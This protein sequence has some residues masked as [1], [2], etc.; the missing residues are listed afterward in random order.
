MGINKFKIKLDNKIYISIL[1]MSGNMD[2]NPQSNQSVDKK[3]SSV[4]AE[5]SIVKPTKENYYEVNKRNEQIIRDKYVL[6]DKTH[7]EV[8]SEIQTFNKNYKQLLELNQLHKQPYFLPSFSLKRLAQEQQEQEQQGQEPEPEPEPE[9]QQQDE[10]AS[11]SQ[12]V[13]NNIVAL[14]CCYCNKNTLMN[15]IQFNSTNMMDI[16]DFKQKSG[17]VPTGE[18]NVN[19]MSDKFCSC[20]NH[21]FIDCSTRKL[22]TVENELNLK[23]FG[24]AA[25][26]DADTDDDD[27]ARVEADDDD[28]GDDEEEGG[29]VKKALKKVGKAADK[30]VGKAADKKVKFKSIRDRNINMVFYCNTC[31]NFFRYECL[32]KINETPS[33]YSDFNLGESYH[34]TL[35]SI[36]KHM[37]FRKPLFDPQYGDNLEKVARKLEVGISLTTDGGFPI[38]IHGGIGST[39]SKMGKL[40]L[41]GAAAGYIGALPGISYGALGGVAGAAASMGSSLYSQRGGAKASLKNVAKGA[42]KV[43]QEVETVAQKSAELQALMSEIGAAAQGMVQARAQAQDTSNSP[44]YTQNTQTSS[45]ATDKPMIQK[46]FGKRYKDLQLTETYEDFI[47]E[48]KKWPL[49]EKEDALIQAFGEVK[50]ETKMTDDYKKYREEYKKLQELYIKDFND[51][52]QE[53]KDFPFRSKDFIFLTELK[54]SLDSEEDKAFVSEPKINNKKIKDLKSQKVDDRLGQLTIK[55]IDR[56]L[57][58]LDNLGKIDLNS[59]SLISRLLNNSG[60]NISSFDDDVK[61][62]LE[63][64]GFGQTKIYTITKGSEEGIKQIVNFTPNIRAIGNRLREFLGTNDDA[65]IKLGIYDTLLNL[66]SQYIKLK[67][68][69]A[70]LKSKYEPLKKEIDDK[71]NKSQSKDKELQLTDVKYKPLLAQMCGRKA[72]NFWYGETDM[73]V[74]EYQMIKEFFEQNKLLFFPFY[75]LKLL[76]AIQKGRQFEFIDR[77]AV[78]A[79]GDPDTG[80]PPSKKGSPSPSKEGATRPEDSQRDDSAQGFLDKLEKLSPENVEYM[81]EVLP[82]FDLLN[83]GQTKKQG[84]VFEITQLMSQ[85]NILSNTSLN[86]TGENIWRAP[87]DKQGVNIVSPIQLLKIKKGLMEKARDFYNTERSINADLEFKK[88]YEKELSKD[89]KEEKQ[90]QKDEKKEEKKAQKEEKKKQIEEKKEEKEAKKLEIEAKKAEIESK[91]NELQ[92]QIESGTI[93]GQQIAQ[94][95]KEIER[96]EKQLDEEEK[97]LAE[98]E[99]HLEEEEKQ[100][101]EEEEQLEEEKSTD[102]SQD[103]LYTK[104]DVSKVSSELD[105]L[106]ME[107]KRKEDILKSISKNIKLLKSQRHGED[108][109]Q[110]QLQQIEYEQK[111]R[112]LI[113][114]QKLVEQREEKLKV[115]KILTDKLSEKNE[116]ELSEMMRRDEINKRQNFLA[117]QNEMNSITEKQSRE[118]SDSVSGIQGE[119]INKLKTK[120][121][122]LEGDETNTQHNIVQNGGGRDKDK[123]SRLLYKT[124]SRKNRTKKKNRNK[125]RGNERKKD[126]SLRKRA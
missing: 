67:E 124:D 15:A 13:Q 33:D 80:A 19:Q 74:E 112:E 2:K 50:G 36:N 51:G 49:A 9:P 72:A 73:K 102:L 62:T 81:R 86:I 59:D 90:K 52:S 104:E 123:L 6:L 108:S 121:N 115:L 26:A 31:K 118:M 1:I 5:T 122:S 61:Y 60:I 37:I 116:K 66:T 32:R 84:T 22:L 95:E 89:S 78:P 91:K 14:R 105:K 24:D 114:F 42:K 68:L 70:E 107:M 99:Q 30:K 8:Q 55:E 12:P 83:P 43:E 87:I 64:K 101:D 125:Y 7:R 82:L 119:E 120:L 54:N 53:F 46:T 110:R 76:K 88:Q 23:A 126:R 48:L 11:F 40:G 65:E 93:N 71:I 16:D 111:Q 69:N 92:N 58:E 41:L 45:F 27:A 75:D 85:N 113:L 38:K 25:A 100:L 20:T 98:E 77:P 29:R 4:T 117:L 106:K 10:G 3:T 39:Y 18:D 57:T 96:E 103:K 94:S 21:E 97:Q 47:S 109:E 56:F 63:G 35:P 17:Y 28:D 44:P 79:L 34:H